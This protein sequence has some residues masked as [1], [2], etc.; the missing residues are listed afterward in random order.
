MNFI[1]SDIGPLSFQLM[2]SP[3]API[4]L[5]PESV[6]Y[7]SGLICY[8]CVRSVP[9]PNLKS[10]IANRLS[11]SIGKSVL[12]RDLERPLEQ[13][14]VLLEKSPFVQGVHRGGGPHM[15]VNEVRVNRGRFLR[16]L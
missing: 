9:L 10:L 6:T 12:R 11:G 8:L 3:P 1:R 7:V 5:F 2:G 15:P 16:L 13:R 14:D 4:L